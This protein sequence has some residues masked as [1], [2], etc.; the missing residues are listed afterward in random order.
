M[1]INRSLAQ[2]FC[3]A[4]YDTPYDDKRI[5][6]RRRNAKERRNEVIRTKNACVIEVAEQ[7]PRQRLATALLGVHKR[8]SFR[9]GCDG[10][11][12][13]ILN[14]IMR[15]LAF[16]LA[17]SLLSALAQPAFGAQPAQ[18]GPPHITLPDGR[19]AY[20]DASRG[21][22][23][24]F[25]KDGR[26][27]QTIRLAGGAAQHRFANVQTPVT[28]SSLI[29]QLNNPNRGGY[30]PGRLIVV[31]RSGTLPRSAD[32][33]MAAKGGSIPTNDFQLNAALKAV[34]A[35]RMTRL[36]GALHEQTA[37][38]A[39][40]AAHPPAFDITNAYRLT[41]TG[42]SLSKAITELKEVPSVLYVSR[43]W[44]VSPMNEPLRPIS[45][46][47]QRT[48]Q[49]ERWALH[50]PFA[51]A[52]GGIGS[53]VPTNFMVEASGQPF[54]NAPGVNAVAAYDE[55][56]R[57]LG[58]L[59]GAGEIITNVS[60][61]DVV[62]EQDQ[63]SNHAD[64]C[65]TEDYYYGPTTET[66][67]GQRYLDWPS[68]PLIPAYVSEANGKIVNEPVCGVDLYD[69][70]IGLD[71]SVMTPLPHNQQR[72]G[73]MGTTLDDLLGVA[74]GA[75]YRLMVPHVGQGP[76]GL[77]MTPT[78]SDILGS[79]I[80]AA[81]QQPAPDV[82]TASIGFGED[83]VGFPGRYWEEDPLVQSVVS[84]IVNGSKIVVCIAA[85]DG[86]RNGMVSIPA[87]GGA[88][89]TEIA[90]KGQAL[91]TIDD[92]A[93]T[94]IPGVIKDSGAIAVG[95]TTL[96]DVIAEQPQ[97]AHTSAK[98]DMGV[99]PETRYDGFASFAS[100][101]GSRVDL[102]APGDNIIAM[103]HAIRAGGP[104]AVTLGI[105]GGTSASAPEVAA[106]AAIALQV[107][108]ATGHPF[109]SPLDVR[110]FLIAHSR[111]VV[112]AP[113]SD[114]LLHV[115]AGI[116]V[117]SM[118][119]TLLQQ[120]GKTLQPGVARVA[121]SQRQPQASFDTAFIGW[122]DPENIPLDGPNYTDGTDS[123]LNLI[124][125]I[126][127][128]PDW[129][130]LPS[131]AKFRLFVKGKPAALLATDS[132]A[133]LLPA[134]ILKAAGLPLA[135]SSYRSVTLTY[136]AS[137]GF[138]SLAQATFSLRFG[139]SPATIEAM[140][141]PQAPAVANGASFPVH[142]DLSALHDA[143]NATLLV[144][145][146]GRIAPFQPNYAESGMIYNPI[147][148]IPLTKKSGTVQI[149][150]SS[151]HG[152]GLYGVVI[153]FG[154][155][156]T[157]GQ[158]IS[159]FAPVHVTGSATESR[160]SAPVLSAVASSTPSQT[161][162]H[163]LEI[164]WHG[165]FQVQ[166]DVSG[167]A[168]ATG[169]VIEISDGD[170]PN[171]GNINRFNNPNGSEIDN[172]GFD[173]GSVYHKQVTGTKGTVTLDAD[174]VGLIP[175]LTHTIRVLPTAGG[176]AIGEASDVDMI[177]EDGLAVASGQVYDYS[178]NESGDDAMALTQ[179]V[180]TD[181]TWIDQ[182][183]RFSQTTGAISGVL[184]S[185][186]VPSGTSEDPCISDIACFNTFATERAPMFGNDTAVYTTDP[187]GS[188][189][190][191]SFTALSPF[192]SPSPAAVAL[193][194]PTPTPPVFGAVNAVWTEFAP[195]AVTTVPFIAFSND[196]DSGSMSGTVNLATG[197]ISPLIDVGATADQYPLADPSG[198]VWDPSTS[199]AMVAV[200]AW[201][202][203]GQLYRLNYST[204][205]IEDTF[206]LPGYDIAQVGDVGI[207][208]A[209]GGNSANSSVVLFPSGI[210][211]YSLVNT[212][213]GVMTNYTFP[214]GAGSTVFTRL[215]AAQAVDSVNHLILLATDD[216]DGAGG[217]NEKGSLYVFDENGNL[218]S[219]RQL[220]AFL[221]DMIVPV[222]GHAT[223]QINPVKRTGFVYGPD[224][225]QIEPFSY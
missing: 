148:Q 113:Q 215:I 199:R 201:S 79:L 80:A 138:R 174:S 147:V 142:Y 70:E 71:F 92:D 216:S 144:G 2:L 45:P 40:S 72:P 62:S 99:V 96:D 18:S 39:R 17:A 89:P 117:G 127:I 74:P 43:D 13:R 219:K 64:A 30:V 110:A 9:D 139:P 37:A 197:A 81:Q 55:I 24:I 77:T 61:G 176:S 131:N 149:P 195:S 93:Y 47:A 50:R 177:A 29:A 76:T 129:E 205:Q 137:L 155:S 5:G 34:G 220:F 49:T 35:T 135:S 90:V 82:I 123:G 67:N 157:G 204:G 169:A 57:T 200:E 124:S 183:Q 221:G 15:L 165:K 28:A 32:L 225:Q 69:S 173:A 116:D 3:N 94:T 101:F 97:Y 66:I 136:E 128:A 153:A 4:H 224:Y 41:V 213:T 31:L 172:D 141:A 208:P 51:A 91:E 26:S 170:G 60:L 150:V 56:V 107:A 184:A 203:P 143:T 179:V 85:N 132:S 156:P 167:V 212:T 209:P 194:I 65:Y 25:S 133:R 119:E 87:Q 152:A 16:I 163:M 6:D 83:S 10:P 78:T 130:G 146:A 11:P 20:V 108:K 120:G 161:T 190:P 54:L 175:A 104:T 1:T 111:P 112:N 168:H 115:G 162:T 73:S 218:I 198:F 187:I 207:D 14:L 84:T 145:E 189:A 22:A 171:S 68:M 151:L 21:Y 88:A 160:P 98:R 154:E 180:D 95:A 159:D 105:T 158:Y 114:V 75:S 58:K 182:V 217:N 103:A 12:V 181:G 125:W 134:D 109:A 52:I 214:T 211:G 23:R 53:A 196:R 188:P 223:M 210:N 206:S 48:A 140:L 191:P 100:G 27:V 222:T 102:S 193:P 33:R 63:P 164:P 106:A 185:S 59:P 122:T 118:V 126:S 202:G 36:F 42:A 166:Y 19:T 121:I 44:Y 186:Q 7:M 8:C 178:I 46:E 192:A 38:M 86:N